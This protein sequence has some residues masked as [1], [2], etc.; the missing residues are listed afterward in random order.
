[1]WS[2]Y[3]Y[4]RWFQDC[5]WQERYARSSSM[6]SVHNCWIFANTTHANRKFK[7]YVSAG[8]LIRSKGHL[9]GQQIEIEK[10]FYHPKWNPITLYADIMLLKLT[11]PFQY[12]ASPH[13]NAEA[14]AIGPICLPDI[15]SREWNYRGETTKV[16][17]FGLTQHKGNQSETLRFIHE[18]VVD[19]ELCEKRFCQ[20]RSKYIYDRHTMLCVGSL[21][22]GISTCQ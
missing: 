10:I 21:K 4:K 15:N 14:T 11:N 2:K 6:A 5:W 13:D 22:N 20:G 16:S 18:K 17:G 9:I 3:K 8:S 1:M 7:Y 19:D 12:R